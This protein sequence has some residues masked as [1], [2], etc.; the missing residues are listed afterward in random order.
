MKTEEFLAFKEFDIE[1]GVKTNRSTFTVESLKQAIIDSINSLEPIRKS[2]SRTVEVVTAILDSYKKKRNMGCWASGDEVIDH[3]ILLEKTTESDML[4]LWLLMFCGQNDSYYF[5]Y[6]TLVVYCNNTM[7]FSNELKSMTE[8]QLIEAIENDNND[9]K[10]LKN[11]LICDKKHLQ[12]LHADFDGE[13][14]ESVELETFLNYMR[15]DPIGQ[16]KIIG[17]NADLA[18]W[19]RENIENNR[20]TDLVPNMGNWFKKLIGKNINYST[21]FQ[22]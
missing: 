6:N 9:K 22:K 19:L 8:Q 17:I 18:I 21:F 5:A 11:K 4:K 16:I 13:I 7:G 3:D 10:N 14:W 1:D 12:K 2:K 20:D 15:V